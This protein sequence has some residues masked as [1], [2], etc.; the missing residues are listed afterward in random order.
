MFSQFRILKN[1]D[2]T[3]ET[4]TIVYKKEKSDFKPVLCVEYYEI[5]VVHDYAIL[6]IKRSDT[7][8]IMVFK[9]LKKNHFIGLYFRQTTHI[10]FAD[11]RSDFGAVI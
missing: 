1:L 10:R 4:S 6:S 8:K 5:I 7:S 9:V 11:V 3:D 2:L